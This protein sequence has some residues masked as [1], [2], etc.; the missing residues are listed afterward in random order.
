[1]AADPA[2]PPGWTYGYSVGGPAGYTITASGDNT[3]ISLP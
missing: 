3:T 2:P 1:M